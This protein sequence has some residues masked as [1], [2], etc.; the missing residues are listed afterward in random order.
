MMKVQFV[1]M[2]KDGIN[3]VCYI[4]LAVDQRC[5]DDQKTIGFFACS[6]EI[7]DLSLIKAPKRLLALA[8]NKVRSSG[9]LAE[10]VVCNC[11]D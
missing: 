9:E 3:M 10:H 11:N 2:K 5:H 6:R 4:F 7:K 8:L 1:S